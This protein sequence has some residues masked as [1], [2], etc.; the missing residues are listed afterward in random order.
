MVGGAGGGS[1]AWSWHDGIMNVR[2]AIVAATLSFGAVVAAGFPTANATSTPPATVSTPATIPDNPFIPDDVNIGDCVSSLPRPNC[3]T[4][5]RGGYE[6]FVVLGLMVA[7]L[8]FIGW[9]I[10]RSV[11]RREQSLEQTPS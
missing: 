2:N 11:R 10:V 7:G 8:S 9:R 1:A 4:T 6:D 5:Q 3:G